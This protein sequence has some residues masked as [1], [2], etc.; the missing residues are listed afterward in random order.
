MRKITINQPA[1][2]GD[3]LFLEPLLRMLSRD[4]EIEMPVVDQY[5]WI[6]EHIPYVNFTP[7]RCQFDSYVQKFT[8]TYY[9]FRFAN[10]IFR[11]LGLHDWSDMENCMLDKYRILGLPETMWMDLQL[12]RNRFREKS[13]FEHLGSPTDFILVNEHSRVGDCKIKLE[14]DLPVIYMQAIDGYSVVDW[15]IM[16]ERA[17]ENH[18]VQTST[19]FLLHMLGVDAKIYPKPDEDGMRGILDLLAM[20]KMTAA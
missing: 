2:V 4:H 11:G 19:L 20:T 1:G 17:K 10:P 18:H 3:I 6:A 13:L 8:A 15:C 7:Y 14:T 16:M 5:A 12:V 9:P